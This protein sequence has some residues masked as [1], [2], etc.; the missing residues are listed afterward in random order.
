MMLT[1]AVAVAAL[2]ACAPAASAY[3]YW[4]DNGPGLSSTGT[5]VGRANLDGS[6]VASSLVTTSPGPGG[7]VSDG[8]HVYWVNDNAGVY[9]IGRA[10][11]DGSG[12][13]LT[14]IAGAA[15]SGGAFAVTTDGTYIYWTDG[16]RYVGRAAVDGTGAVG[17]FID[18]G[19]GR[20]PFGIAAYG[21]VLYV[22]EFAQIMR[23]ASSGG[24]SPTLFT[25]ISGQV[26]VSL[27]AAGGTSTGPRI[28][29]GR[30]R[31]ALLA[32]RSRRGRALSRAM[33]RV[34]RT[35]PGS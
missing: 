26:A 16:S 14:F 22:G 30:L 6:G 13:N 19:S 3:L 24:S 12:A 35:Q 9:S 20:A 8:S 32:A 1:F 33:C 27:A 18:M 5:T 15:M 2:A 25:A 21:G 34:C 4:T 10:N 7:I 23:V 28:C 29:R 11:L 17:H 31:A